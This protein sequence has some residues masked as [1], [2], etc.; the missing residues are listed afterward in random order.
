MIGMIDSVRHRIASAVLWGA[1][2]AIALLLISICIAAA[3]AFA[4]LAFYFYLHL[5]VQMSSPIAAAATGG[6]AVALAALLALIGILAFRIASRPR[7]STAGPKPGFPS[8]AAGSVS[9]NAAVDEAASWIAKNPRA[10]VIAAFTTG[11]VF[12]LSPQLRQAV[13]DLIVVAIRPPP[14]RQ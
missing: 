14:P 8:P 4:L 9:L 7:G 6:M 3:I 1:L 5:S 10:A 11:S 12:G 13:A 2:A